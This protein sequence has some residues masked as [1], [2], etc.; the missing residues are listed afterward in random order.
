MLEPPAIVNLQSK[1]CL[2]PFPTIRIIFT[3]NLLV[4]IK[5]HSVPDV[6]ATLLCRPVIRPSLELT[7]DGS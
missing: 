1:H 3:N 4:G 5:Y 6:P 7:F 2:S